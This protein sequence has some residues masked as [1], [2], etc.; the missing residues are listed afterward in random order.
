MSCSVGETVNEKITIVGGKA[1]SDP[2][3]ADFILYVHC[4]NDATVN[5]DEKANH[6]RDLIMGQTPVALVDLSQIMILKKLSFP[7][8]LTIIRH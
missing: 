1:V 4:G 6:L 8:L 3:Q 7:I 5:L 2:L